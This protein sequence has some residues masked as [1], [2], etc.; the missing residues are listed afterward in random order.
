MENLEQIE[1]DFDSKFTMDGEGTCLNDRY[2]VDDIKDFLRSKFTEYQDKIDRLE[3]AVK[4]QKE[5][6]HRV[7]KALTNI[8]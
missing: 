1:K 3:W 8:K 7:L 6:N 2:I 4:A 5:L